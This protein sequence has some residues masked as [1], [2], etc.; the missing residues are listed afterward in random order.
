MH[1]CLS[2]YTPHKL[3]IRADMCA[4]DS[5]PLSQKQHPSPTNTHLLR[6]LSTV[7]R[8]EAHTFHI[9]T[10]TLSGTFA[11]HVE[12]HK[13]ETLEELDAKLSCGKLQTTWYALC[14]KSPLVGN[15]YSVV[16]TNAK[17]VHL[18]L[19]SD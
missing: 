9:C 5:S 11:F 1:L 7:G 15:C 10:L 18:L 19:L 12:F 17:L 3:T 6:R 8:I 4:I 14:G 2:N 13:A 16:M